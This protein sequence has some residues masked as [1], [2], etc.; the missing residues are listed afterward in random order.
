ML[1][2]RIKENVKCP[3]HPRYNPE[4]EGESGIKGGC[5]HCTAL[6]GLF[7]R[8]AKLADDCSKFIADSASGLT[9]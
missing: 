9:K 8:A 7:M 6:F 1:K 4:L 5:V 2:I 3:R